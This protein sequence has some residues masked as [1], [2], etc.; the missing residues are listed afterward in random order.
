[1]ATMD[2][3]RLAQNIIRYVGGEDNVQSLVHCTTRLR[4][5]LADDKKVNKTALQQLQGVIQVIHMAGQFQLVIGN[6]VYDIYREILRQTNIDSSRHNTSI[7]QGSLFN[8]AI[9]TISGIFIPLLSALAGAGI[10]K[11]LL[12]L[13]VSLGLIEEYTGT[14]RI[15]HAAADSLFY[16]LPMLLAYTAAKKFQADPIVAVVIAGALLYPDLVEAYQLQENLTFFGIPIILTNYATSV[17]PIIIAIYVMSKLQQLLNNWVHVTIRTFVVPL[18]LIAIMVPSTLLIFG[19]I[20]TTLGNMMAIGYMYVYDNSAFFA[21]V[22]IGFFWQI[23]VIFG[24]HW[25]I[26]PIAFN[27]ISHYSMDTLTAMLTPAVFG[28]AGATLGVWLKTKDKKM[29]QIA[30]PAAFSGIL[31]VTEPAIYGVTLRLKRPFFIGCFAGALGGG[32]AGLAGTSAKSI[33]LPGLASLPVFLGEGFLLFLVAI[34]GSF[35]LAVILTYFFGQVDRKETVHETKTE[36]K[37]H[38]VINKLEIVSPLQ[39]AVIPL[40]EVDDAVFSS[41]AAGEGVAVIPVKETVR[42]PISGTVTALFPTHHALSITAESG[43]QILIHLGINTVQ[44]E[45]KYFMMEV[46][47]GDQVKQG[48]KIGSF[49]L[50]SIVDKGYNM[51]TPIVITN[52]DSDMEIFITE[53]ENI[54]FNETLLTVMK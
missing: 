15:L 31:G 43:V 11:G 1:M 35:L 9:D 20:G 18:L 37:N 8:R 48:D 29:K 44:L 34:V 14:Y 49:D 16:F 13:T 3:Q 27:N 46:Q 12:L 41:G 45:G 17:I 2:I 4:F 10:L 51:T 22:T 25:G 53:A 32:L 19:P 28:Q 23:L 38:S 21:G 30:G 24:S 50:A 33:A 42:A 52:S 5:K 26:T 40:S 6:E 47:A 39:G 54:T 36:A 7:L